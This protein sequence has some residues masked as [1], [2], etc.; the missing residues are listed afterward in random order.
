MEHKTTGAKRNRE[1]GRGRWD[2]LPFQGIDCV[3]QVLDE[4]CKKYGHRNWEKGLPVFESYVDHALQHL[5]KLTVEALGMSSFNEKELE[6][7][8]HLA[9]AA[10]NLL[11]ALE[12]R[13]RVR[14]GDL[15]EELM[16]VQ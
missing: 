10:C 6:D 15:P 13:A 2:L 16:S 4:G 11:M 3:A 9:H 8:D 14:S 7:E 1:E 5:A 12:T